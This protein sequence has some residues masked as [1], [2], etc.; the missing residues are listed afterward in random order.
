MDLDGLPGAALVAR[1]LADLERGEDT[2]EAL[3]VAIGRARLQRAG[4]AIPARA[5]EIREGELRLYAEIGRTNPD[6]A[7]GRYNS[8]LRELVSFERALEHRVRR[9]SRD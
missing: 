1:G 8:L 5:A 3:L 4:L 2:V 7:Y 9:Q 6:D